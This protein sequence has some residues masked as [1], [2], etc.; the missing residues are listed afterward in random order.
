M[1]LTTAFKATIQARALRDSAFRKPPLQEGV[2][3]LLSDDVDTGKVVLRG[4]I[5]ATIGFEPLAEVFGKSS[6]S[7]MRVFGLRGKP[8]A[9][10][11]FAVIYDL[12]EEEGLHLAVEAREVA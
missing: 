9:S 5:H 2:E 4:Y 10:N 1:A 3:C 11:L 6:K 8:Q 12:Q 7:L